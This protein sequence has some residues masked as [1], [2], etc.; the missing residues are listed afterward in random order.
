MLGLPAAPR[1]RPSPDPSAEARRRASSMNAGVCWSWWWGPPEPIGAA[2]SEVSDEP[3][4]A[5]R[6]RG[7]AVDIVAGDVESRGDR[8]VGRAL[9]RN[10]KMR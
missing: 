7:V 4:V 8:D 3:E 6:A 2:Q 5:A 1:L 10:R 9:K